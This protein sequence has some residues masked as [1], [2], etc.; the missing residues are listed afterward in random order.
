[1]AGDSSNVKPVN[2]IMVDSI[3]LHTITKKVETAANVYPGRLV[4]HG[5]DDGDIVVCDGSTAPPI[6]WAG[7]EQT[8]KKYRPATV[9]TIYVILDQIAV[10]WGP[11]TK[12][13]ARINGIGAAIVVGTLLKSAAAGTLTP[14]VAGTDDIV[15]I[16]EEANAGSAASDIIVRSRI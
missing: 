1:M 7:Y 11:G 8:A 4:M 3:G 13:L 12:F 5:T 2:A 9:D 16:A 6:G 15:A 14:G 10:C